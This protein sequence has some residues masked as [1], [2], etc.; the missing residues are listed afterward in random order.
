MVPEP[1]SAGVSKASWSKFFGK[2]DKELKSKLLKLHQHHHEK[3]C[4]ENLEF[5][6]IKTPSMPFFCVEREEFI[7]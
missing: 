7:K 6:I 5:D 2:D 3:A 1:E 4:R